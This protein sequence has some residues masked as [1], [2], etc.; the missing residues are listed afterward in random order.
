KQKVASTAYDSVD[1]EGYSTD[2]ERRNGQAE[3]CSACVGM[4]W[5]VDIVG[6]GVEV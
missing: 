1:A 5:L 4:G 3:V 6:R 2:D